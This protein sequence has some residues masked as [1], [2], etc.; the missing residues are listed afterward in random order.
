[1]MKGTLFLCVRS[2]TLP[3][4]LD[5]GRFLLSIYS[6]NFVNFSLTLKMSQEVGGPHVKLNTGHSMPLVGFGT[7]KVKNLYK[8]LVIFCFRLLV[9]KQ[10]MLLLMPHCLQATALLTLQNIT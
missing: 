6:D 4:L 5:R 10:L 2:L 9:K 7:Y 3:I 8:I 1:M